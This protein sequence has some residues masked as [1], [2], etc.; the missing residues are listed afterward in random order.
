M[1]CRRKTGKY[2]FEYDSYR[3]LAQYDRAKKA[4]SGEIPNPRMA[5]I[6]PTY[7]C[8]STCIGCEYENINNKKNINLDI[9]ALIRL[10]GELREAGVDSVEFSG[11][12]EPSLYPYL[13][14][15]ILACKSLGMS[16]GILTNGVNIKGK[17]GKILAGETSYIRIS[18][19]AATEETYRKIYRQDTNG[20]RSVL[21]NIRKL[22]SDRDA[23]GS[24][25]LISVK[26]LV[27]EYNKHEIAK[28]FDLSKELGVDSLQFK[29]LRQ[30]AH[31]VSI[32]NIQQLSSQIA[33][34]K[35]NPALKV[36]GSVE[37]E[38]IRNRCRLTPLQTTISPTGDVYLCNYFLRRMDR[39]CIGNIMEDTFCDIWNSD[40]HIRAI[41]DIRP[42][43]CNLYDC[44]FIRYSKIIEPI[45]KD[46]KNQLDF[47]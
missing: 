28:A 4:Y 41:S 39:H 44:R 12:G 29:T 38:H 7:N 30:S 25:L 45:I 43:E 8:N 21:K 11:G 42:G 3:I 10:L 40:R 33:D 31:E 1:K 5:I 16:V 37:K 24:G 22:V 6:Y 36:I 46:T 20:F 23:S 35:N 14:Q 19:S 26:F 2:I 32:E 27:S 47:I 13:G 15:A 18:L 17:L 34:L 9:T